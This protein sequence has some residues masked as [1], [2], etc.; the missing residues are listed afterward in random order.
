MNDNQIKSSTD[1]CLYLLETTGVVT[2]AGD[3]FGSRENIRISYATSEDIIIKA[4]ELIKET[5]LKLS[6]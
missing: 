1:L 6:F 3:S 4:V 5:L 2:V